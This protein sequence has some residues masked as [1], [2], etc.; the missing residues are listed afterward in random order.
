VYL[1]ITNICPCNCKF[2]LRNEGDGINPNESLWLEHEPTLEEIIS[3]LEKLDF[4]KYKEA[5]FCGYGEPTERLDIMLKVATFL[6]SHLPIRLNTNGLSDLINKDK[7][8]H[9]LKGLIDRVSISL[10]APNAKL[11]NSLC[12]PMFDATAF[13]AVIQFA[14]DCKEHIA[15]VVMSVVGSTLTEQDIAECTELCKSLDISLRIR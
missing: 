3:E 1:N 2:C 12:L 13:D 9:K 5:V 7:T 10:N 8:A 6:K 14:K 11:Y 4:T 15:D